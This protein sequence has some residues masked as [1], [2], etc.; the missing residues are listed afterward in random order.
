MSAKQ[1]LVMQADYGVVKIDGLNVYL[2]TPQSK[3]EEFK[4]G[5]PAPSHI[6]GCRT[7]FPFPVSESSKIGEVGGEVS[8][9]IRT[10]RGRV[11]RVVT[12]SVSFV[13]GD[14]PPTCTKDENRG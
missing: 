4:A 8:E 1:T 9:P 12:L 2:V 5:S 13:S 11:K 6:D 3:R 7:T 14:I 10:S